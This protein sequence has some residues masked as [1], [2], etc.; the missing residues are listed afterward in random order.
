MLRRLALL[1]LALVSA[2]LVFPAA[3][4]PAQTINLSEVSD[5]MICAV[6]IRGRTP[7]TSEWSQYPTQEI[8]EA[9]RRGFTPEYCGCMM[10]VTASHMSMDICEARKDPGRRRPVAPPTE[11][12]RPTNEIDTID[13]P[14]TSGGDAWTAEEQAAAAAVAASLAALG[15]ASL[16]S[17]LL[18][19]RAGLPREPLLARLLDAL[20]GRIPD[21]FRAWKDK[22]TKLGWRYQ[23]ANGVA[24]FVPVAGSRN[25][26]GWI[27]DPARGDFVASAPAAPR[28]GQLDAAT[29]K[30]WSENANDWVPRDYYEQERARTGRYAAQEA[31]QRADADAANRAAMQAESAHNAQAAHEIAAGQAALDAQARAQAHQDAAVLAKLRQAYE[32]QGRSTDDLG[33]LAGGGHSQE[34]AGL[35]EEHLRSAIAAHANEAARQASWAD[36]MAVGEYAA[37]AA[38]AAAKAGLVVAGGPATYGGVLLGGAIQATQEGT[39]AFVRGG[40]ARKVAKGL[41]TGFLFGAKDVLVGRYANVPGAGVGTRIL[42]PAAGDAFETYVRTG[43]GARTLRA[44]LLSAVGGQVGGMLG[45]AMRPGAGL[46]VAQV[47][48]S[49]ALGAAG[50]Q[51]EG[52]SVTEGLLEGLS[53]GLGS[54]AGGHIA[55]AHVP[56]TATDIQMDRDAA[57]AMGKGHGLIE[58][59]ARARTPQEQA[60]AVNRLLEDHAAKLLMKNDDNYPTLKDSF[61]Q[62]VHKYR[63]EPVL[64]DASKSLNDRFGV[65]AMDETGKPYLREIS[66]ADFQS[67]SSSTKKPGMDLDVFTES[68]I[69]DRKAF[70]AARDAHA[71]ADAMAKLPAAEPEVIE[72][73]VLEAARGRGVD[74][75]KQ[76]INVI[77]RFHPEAL[78]KPK[79]ETFKSFLRRPG[80]YSPSEAE[81]VSSV[82]GFKLTH[83][84]ELPGGAGVSLIETCRTGFKDYDRFAGPMLDSH[85]AATLPEFL[86]TVDGASGRSGLD[87]IKAVG[88]GTLPPGTGNAQFRAI[89]GMDLESG[90][91]KMTGLPEAIAKL[92]NQ[93]SGPGR[94]LS[95]TYVLNDG[96]AI[97]QAAV[98]DAIRSAIGGGD[99]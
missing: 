4:A 86:R 13:K 29:G 90:V 3:D 34:L 81:S 98:R 46:A 54:V 82:T 52:G 62:A 38:L 47:G 22:Y 6:A 96:R 27:F 35:Y 64:G 71:D 9:K 44:G 32:A 72:G 5:W 31:A 17:L 39:D 53:N 18:R 1:V 10:T 28:D 93:G 78:S 60:P 74:P 33:R 26:Q 48:L 51:M 41:A 88:D 57:A 37:R 45:G 15:F 70:E 20:R 11:Q 55:S 8:E 7:A 79:D 92:G 61:A 2:G 87:I 91:Q 85:P 63:T 24:R 21:P 30:V 42:A 14:D 80:S 97:A 94:D 83:A 40:N 67:G 49:G 25:E 73:A 16:A 19:V 43:D 69:V 23:E 66:P 76:E 65:L 89:T 99:P 56:M 59:F 68:K 58:D 36:A 50:Q 95:V 77:D 12:A 75:E 84:A